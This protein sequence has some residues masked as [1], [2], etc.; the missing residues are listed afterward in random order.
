MPDTLRSCIVAEEGFS[1]ISL[2]AIQVE[3][4]VLAYLSQDSQMIEDV[5]T[6]DIHT[7]T[8]IRMFGWTDDAEEMKSRRYKAKQGNFAEVYEIGDDGLADLLECS[9]E[10]VQAFREERRKTYPRL[11]EWKDEVKAK[12]KEVGYVISMFGRIRP[13]PELHGG[14]WKIR[15]K[16]E[17]EIVNSIVQGTAVDIVKLAGLYMRSVLDYK[18][19]FVLMVHDEWLFECPDNILAQAIEQCKTLEQVFPNYPFKITVGKVYNRL[20]EVDKK[21]LNDA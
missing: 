20:T 21:E 10:E 8:A 2:D 18:V 16:A 9:L 12:A 3:L 1:F 15:E 6:G 13:L 4:K 17:R 7:A 5:E 19:R 14:T 11:Y